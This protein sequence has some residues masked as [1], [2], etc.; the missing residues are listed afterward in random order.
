MLLLLVTI[1]RFVIQFGLSKQAPSSEF[2]TA[3]PSWMLR[4]TSLW[5]F[6]AEVLP[7][8][9]LILLAFFLHKA[10]TRSSSEGIWKYIIMGTGLSYILIAAHWASESKLLNW[11]WVLEYVGRNSIPRLVYAIGVG[12]L[13]IL[14]VNQLFIKQRSSEGS[15]MLSTKAVAMFSVWSSTIIILLG[16]QGPFIALAFIIGGG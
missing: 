4:I 16:K 3:Y 12:Q 1:C 8:P 9:A 7:V 10:I 5:N 11:A 2:V 13:L 15:R 6:V 14:A